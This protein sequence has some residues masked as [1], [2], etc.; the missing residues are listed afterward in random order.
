MKTIKNNCPKRIILKFSIALSFIVLISFTTQAQEVKNFDNE[1]IY[2][3]EKSSG[4]ASELFSLYYDY[5]PTLLIFNGEKRFSEQNSKIRIAEVN[6]SNLSELSSLKKDLSDIELIR[7]IYNNGDKPEK[8]DFKTLN[9]L[10][11]LKAVVFQCDFNCN[12]KTIEPL[13]NNYKNKSIQIF[14]LIS[15]PE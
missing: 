7:V 14:Y 13:L 5:H 8:I 1:F 3:K 6:V 10:D 4:S 11:K 12:E 2:S 9:D 15:I